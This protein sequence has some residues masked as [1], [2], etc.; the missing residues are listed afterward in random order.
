MSS[1]R[2]SDIIWHMEREPVVEQA[3]IRERVGEVLGD[4]VIGPREYRDEIVKADVMGMGAYTAQTQSD[5]PVEQLSRDFMQDRRYRLLS[6][7]GHFFDLCTRFGARSEA[8]QIV[9][10]RAQEKI[11]RQRAE[12]TS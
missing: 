3:S 6:L 1:L 10:E 4:L 9:W 2:Q 8:Q 5:A 12:I 7:A 11:A